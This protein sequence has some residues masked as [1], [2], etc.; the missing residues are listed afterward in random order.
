[1]VRTERMTAIV[2]TG[3]MVGVL[4]ACKKKPEAAPEASA[5]PPA[6]A[7]SGSD[8]CSH[9]SADW[10]LHQARRREALRDRQGKEAG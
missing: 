9:G 4:L 6:D 3:L 10:R 8:A 7:G 2:V 5:T 1:M